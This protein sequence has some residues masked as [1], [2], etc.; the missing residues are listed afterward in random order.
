LSETLGYAEHSD[1]Y[2]G[3]SDETVPVEKKSHKR[4]AA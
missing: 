4:K 3:R 2:E 1:P